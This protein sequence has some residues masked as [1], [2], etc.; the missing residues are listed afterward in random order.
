MDAQSSSSLPGANHCG[1]SSGMW[2]TC[3]FLNPFGQ[4]FT[5]VALMQGGRQENFIVRE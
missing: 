4:V 5:S 1:Q 3:P 2:S